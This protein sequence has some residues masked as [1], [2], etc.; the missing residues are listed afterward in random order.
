MMQA[1]PVMQ[2]THPILRYYIFNI[3]E[4]NILRK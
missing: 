3:F 2:I 1:T 4:K